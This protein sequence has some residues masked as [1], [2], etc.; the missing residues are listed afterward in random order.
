MLNYAAEREVRVLTLQ[1]VPVPYP[2]EEERRERFVQEYVDIDEF[3]YYVEDA[4][5]IYIISV[6]RS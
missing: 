4:E 1:I 2:L 6:L 5:E 3:R